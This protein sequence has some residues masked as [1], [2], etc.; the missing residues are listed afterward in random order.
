MIRKMFCLYLTDSNALVILNFNVK[1][2]EKNLIVIRFILTQFSGE[3]SKNNRKLFKIRDFFIK[4][5][6]KK[7]LLNYR[8]RSSNVRVLHFPSQKFTCNQRLFLYY[9]S[10]FLVKAL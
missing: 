10:M 6:I 7:L 9:S 4:Q 5:L 8:R 2:K 3:V 1:L